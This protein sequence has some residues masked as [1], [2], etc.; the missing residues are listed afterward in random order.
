MQQLPLE[1]Q[2]GFSYAEGK[3]IGVEAAR[4]DHIIWLCI[5]IPNTLW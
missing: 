3:F 2:V 4:M 5:N 1:E